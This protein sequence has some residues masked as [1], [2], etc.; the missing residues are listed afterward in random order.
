MKKIILV[1]GIV[2]MLVI[3]WNKWDERNYWGD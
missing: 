3:M 1:A 2:A